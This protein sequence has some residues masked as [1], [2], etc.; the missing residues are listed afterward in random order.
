MRRQKSI[1]KRCNT[2]FSIDDD[3]DEEEAKIRISF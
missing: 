3:D 1:M 2:L